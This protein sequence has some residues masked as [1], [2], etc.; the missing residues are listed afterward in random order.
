MKVVRSGLGGHQER[1]PRARSVL[2]GIVVRQNLELL[3]VVNGRQNSD[4]TTRQFVVVR[5]IQEPIGAVRAGTR[6]RQG[7]RTA[8]RHFAARASVEKAVGVRFLHGARS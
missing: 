5:A 6:N 7:K 4:S 2:R 8:R 3:N 1:W